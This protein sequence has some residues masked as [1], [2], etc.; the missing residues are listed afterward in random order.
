MIPQP[1]ECHVVYKPT[2]QAQIA[3]LAKKHN[4]SISFLVGDDELGEAKM[5]YCTRRSND[6]KLLEA[7]MNDLTKDS[8]PQ[9]VL[10]QKIECVM[11]DVISNA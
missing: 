8:P 2:W 4:F 7:Q 9:S 11:M 6:F 1:F 5:M 10:R 3:P